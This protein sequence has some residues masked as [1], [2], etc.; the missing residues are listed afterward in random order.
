[1]AWACPE[2]EPAPDNSAPGN[3][4]GWATNDPPEAAWIISPSEAELP[5]GRQLVPEK[6]DPDGPKVT[7]RDPGEVAE[8]APPVTIDIAFQ[9]D[10]GATVDFKT[11]KVTYLKLFGIDITE[12]L[13][14]YVTADGIHA[15][16]APLAPGHHSIEISVNDT[17]GR[18]TVERFTF[19]VLRR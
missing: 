6:S 2:G 17:A 14:P 9:A 18:R 16:N 10:D 11:L 3:P 4:Q 15:V 7:V 19:T 8:V 13:L 12:R 1:M 5:L